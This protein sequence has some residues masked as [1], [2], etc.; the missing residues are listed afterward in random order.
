VDI[1]LVRGVNSDG[2]VTHLLDKELAKIIGRKD[3]PGKPYLYGTTKQ[4]LEYFGLRSLEDLPK[5]EEFG[6]LLEKGETTGILPVEGDGTMAEGEEGAAGEAKTA[7]SG[8]GTN[9]AKTS[10]AETGSEESAGSTGEDNAV[11]ETSENDIKNE[12]LEEPSKE[13]LEEPSSEGDEQQPLQEDSHESQ[14]S[15]DE[16]R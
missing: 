15:A 14:K 3:V 1:E 16:D 11:E 12:V 4:F 7:E 5:L 2:V 8:E 6:T 9:E 10:G 13:S